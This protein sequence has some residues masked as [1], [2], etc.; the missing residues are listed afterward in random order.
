MY[1]NRNADGSFNVSGKTISV[2]RKQLDGGI[3]QRALVDRLQL[4]GVD[5]DKNA[6]QKIESGKRFVTDIEL[7]AFAKVFDVSAGF[8]LGLE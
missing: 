8:L 4:V 7:R 1:K 2:L 6:I 5:L 3:S